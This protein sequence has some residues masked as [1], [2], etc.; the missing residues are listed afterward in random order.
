MNNINYGYLRKNTSPGI[1]SPSKKFE[2]N[3]FKSIQQN[4]NNNVD[5]KNLFHYI[6]TE[7]DQNIDFPK[8]IN[9]D[10]LQNMEN[11]IVSK[12]YKD[13]GSDIPSFKIIN[14]NQNGNSIINN[15]KKLSNTI[16]LSNKKKFKNK[17]NFNNCI[18]LKYIQYNPN[19][20][21]NLNYNNKKNKKGLNN[22]ILN[23]DNNSNKLPKEYELNGP[24][25]DFHFN[26][27]ND[28]INTPEKIHF[29]KIS[30]KEL[31]SKIGVNNKHNKNN[32]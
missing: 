22:F 7:Y 8:N 14:K 9:M 12:K 10:T 6:N 11:K 29:N 28:L 5:N 4:I 19:A 2:N 27:Q 18:N 32:K 25:H 1:E 30:Y 26:K 20:S 21:N 24:S 16:S 17:V 13:I 31:N 23:N 15:N 3:N